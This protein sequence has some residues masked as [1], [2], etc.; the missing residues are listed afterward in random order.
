MESGKTEITNDIRKI[1]IFI[2][3]K[4]FAETNKTII[5][6]AYFKKQ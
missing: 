2:L 3:K 5:F 1:Y 4:C 6:A